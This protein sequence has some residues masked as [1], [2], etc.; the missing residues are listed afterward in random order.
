M[1]KFYWLNKGEKISDVARCRG[2][3]RSSVNTI[4]QNREKILQ[5]QEEGTSSKKL[6]KPKFE[7]LDQ[8]MLSWFHRQRQNNMPLSGP[9]VKAQAEKFSEEL[10]LTDFKASEGWLGKF[11]QRHHI[12]YGKIYGETRSIDKNVT[13]DWINKVWPKLI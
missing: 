2:L 9:I 7:E 1:K 12:N 4:W 3:S 13:Q 5:A 8:A 11:K 6:R 10:G